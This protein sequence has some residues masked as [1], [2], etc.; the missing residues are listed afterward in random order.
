MTQTTEKFCLNW[1]DFQKNI[2]SSMQEL[3][4]D[5]DLTDVTLACEDRKQFLAHK[6]ILS[7]SS[8]FFKKILCNNKHQHPL[9]YLKGMKAEALDAVL[10]FLYRGEK[11]KFTRK[12][13]MISWLLQKNWSLKA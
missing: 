6:F 5:L 12:I 2:T 8:P 9:I 3:R 10:D 7:A 11:S 4:D 13:L 1:K